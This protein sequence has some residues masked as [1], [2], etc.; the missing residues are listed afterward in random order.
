MMMRLMQPDDLAW[1]LTLTQ[2]ANWSHRLEDWQFQSRLGRGWVACDD[3]GTRLGTA[4]WWAYGPA[5]GSVGL[6][7]VD[8]RHQGKGI[9]RQLMNKIIDD[10]GARTLQLVAT[11]AGHK[12]YL[13]CGFRDVGGI[14]Q[15]Q[16][17]AV[18][19]DRG[20]LPN[21]TTL[22]AVT[23]DDLPALT[24]LDS[25][26]FGGP[27]PAL[28]DSVLASGRGVVAERGGRAIGF[29]LIRRAG[30][31]MLIGPLVAG[32]E[33]LAIALTDQ[34]L[35]EQD[36]FTRIDVPTDAKQLA[37]WLEAAGLANVDEV[38]SMARGKVAE[39]TGMRTYGLV[40]QALG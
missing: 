26:A 10:A 5:L 14:E 34:L 39:S 6:V 7:L 29:A 28:I 33:T 1:G 37:A 12:L 4:T 9:G 21:D 13:D 25:A 18:L 17:V 19:G 16:G 35:R 22:R 24:E 40:S 31:G 32:D 38:T 2:A 36:G 27:R 3:D 23:R 20:S 30:R 8:G 11:K 15:H